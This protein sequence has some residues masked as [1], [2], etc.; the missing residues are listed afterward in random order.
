M[1]YIILGRYESL[2]KLRMKPHGFYVSTHK[3]SILLKV[4]EPKMYVMKLWNEQWNNKMNKWNDEM[5]NEIM[6]WTVKW[7]NPRRVK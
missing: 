1:Y 5:N 6:K 3:Y 4:S 7:W 2:N